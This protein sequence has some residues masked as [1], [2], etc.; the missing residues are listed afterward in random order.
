MHAGFGRRRDD[1]F[2]RRIGVESRDVLR[3]RPGEQFDVLR[4]IADLLSEHI[5]GPLIE[6]GAIEPDGA[7]QRLPNT[8]NRTH[9]RRFAGS[10][11]PDDAEPL[12]GLKRERH[13][14][15]HDTLLAGRGDADAFH[16]QTLGRRLERRRNVLRRHQLQH[17]VEPPP[18]F[19]R[20]NEATPV[21][22]RQIDRRQRP[23]TEDRSRDD[24]AGSGLLI[25]HQ[26]SADAEHSRLHRHAHDL[27]HRAKPAGDIAD[28]LIAAEISAIR[29]V[30]QAGHVLR[31][32]HR[33]EHLGV[34]VTGCGDLNAAT[35]DGRRGLR[36]R[37]RQHFG[38]D[39]NDHQ[40]DGARE[41]GKADQRM[42]C[43][44][45]RQIQRQPGQI[46][47]RTGP[48]TGQERT[49]VV[50]VAQGLQSLATVAQR[51]RIAH[52]DLVDAAA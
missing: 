26:I 43:K 46:E 18:A 13:V 9:Q 6:R 12:P 38:Q 52:H 7:A 40:N 8:D 51:Q 44:T 35:G 33:R 29:L 36:T 20:R 39:G 4:Q 17:R 41:C 3:H 11:R 2:R 21:R 32:P 31:H 48:R 28:L 5:G 15:H 16:R 47:E 1:G 37:A 22:D 27:G 25:D 14:L 45:D 10:A 42:E 24:D 49:N 19:A 30:P 50:E 34:A 23:R